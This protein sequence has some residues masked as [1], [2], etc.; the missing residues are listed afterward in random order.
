MF[1]IAD[2]QEYWQKL[3]EK[4]LEEV[5]E[6]CESESPEELADL[7][8]VIDAIMEYKQIPEDVVI[9]LQKTKQIKRGA[10]TKKLILEKS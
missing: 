2:E 7:Y 10:F 6:F 5:R 3:K 1:H 8:E 4:L 9:A